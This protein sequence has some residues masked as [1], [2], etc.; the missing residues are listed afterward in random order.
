MEPLSGVSC[1]KFDVKSRAI[2]EL[3]QANQRYT[4]RASDII[5][6]MHTTLKLES[7]KEMNY[8]SNDI[9][10]FKEGSRINFPI[11]FCLWCVISLAHLLLKTSGGNS[12]RKR[13]EKLMAWWS[14]SKRDDGQ[15]DKWTDNNS[16]CRLD[17]F[18]WRGQVKLIRKIKNGDIHT[19]WQ[20][21]PFSVRS[22]T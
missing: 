1:V 12:V 13:K 4:R 22:W 15:I 17:P 3:I 14:K 21:P 8:I 11:T 9:F 2:P 20:W 5:R 16:S 19:H 6:Q 10:W 7:K 18:C